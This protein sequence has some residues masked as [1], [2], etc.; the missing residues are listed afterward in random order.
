MPDSIEPIRFKFKWLDDE[1]NTTSLLRKSASYDGRVLQLDDTLIPVDAIAGVQVRWDRIYLLLR[2]ESGDWVKPGFAVSGRSLKEIQHAL[3]AQCRE[4]LIRRERQR[5]MEQGDLPSL[6][7]QECHYCR[8][9]ILLSGLPETPQVYCEVCD[10]LFTTD[11]PAEQL[12]LEKQYRICDECGMYSHP[13][14]F[15]IF[16]FYFLVVIYGIWNK[17]TVRCPACMR[18]E[19][20]KM[21]LGNMPGL[22]G[23]PFSV[24]QLYRSYSTRSIQGPMRGLDDANI[25]LK[26]DKI[27]QALDDYE[28]LMD[29]QP[30]NAGIK[31]NIGT[32]L[33][34]QQE[35]QHAQQAFE[36]S[37]D[38]CGNYWPALQGL[39]ATL[40]QQGKTVEI[41]AVRKLWQLE[42][43]DDDGEATG[44]ELQD[45]VIPK[46]GQ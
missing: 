44:N 4:T 18:G 17:T 13:R 12:S 19:S 20:W 10:S 31:Y 22:I 21:L 11:A 37:L 24:V 35:F 14:R 43:V 8:A 15:T 25:R 30:I 26:K 39:L 6:R 36:M 32:G 23:L 5:L 1:G 2:T 29:A 42:Q 38:D 28:K 33:V 7:E 27:D 40:E 3:I 41:E 9:T 34:Q 46:D 45:D 16:Y